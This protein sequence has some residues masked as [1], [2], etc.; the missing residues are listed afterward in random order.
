MTYSVRQYDKRGCPNIR[1][2]EE[3]AV[4]EG[5]LFVTR[6]RHEWEAGVNR[7][8]RPGETFVL[9]GGD[10][11]IVGMCGLNIDPYFDDST[12]GRLRHLYIHPSQRRAGVARALVQTCLSAASGTF[13][14]V[15]LRTS[16]PAAD[17]LYRSLGFRIVQ[18]PTATHEW[19]LRRAPRAWGS[20][21]Q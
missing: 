15:R 9:F 8:D 2:L 16:N 4:A 18:Q 19:S 10:S 14:R 1:D 17:A 20:S 11:Q 7:F 21:S 12:V 3:I 13:D 6:T 5:H